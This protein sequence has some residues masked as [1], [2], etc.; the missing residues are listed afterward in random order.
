[1]TQ[2]DSDT[3]YLAVTLVGRDGKRRYDSQSKRRLVEACLQPGVSVAG[4]ALKAGVNANLLRRWIKLHQ[5]RC[6]MTVAREVVEDTPTL[7]V[8]SPFVEIQHRAVVE[9]TGIVQTC[10]KP[11]RPSPRAPV[12]SQLTVEMPNGITLRLDCTGQDAPLVSAMIETLGRCD[13]QARR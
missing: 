4:L 11:A 8:P 7:V 1:M 6:G 13:V 9:R 5:Q 2:T 3:A 10:P 12:R